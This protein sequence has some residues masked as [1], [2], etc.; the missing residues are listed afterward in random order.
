MQTISAFQIFHQTLSLKNTF[1]V[2]K[3]CHFSTPK[4]EKSL[5]QTRLGLQYQAPAFPLTILKIL[6]LI[7]VPIVKWQ[8]G[9]LVSN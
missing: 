4:L 3:I 6:G 2:G 7:Q 8:N 9:L 5:L 1:W